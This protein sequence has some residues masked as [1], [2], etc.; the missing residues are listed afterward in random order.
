METN[1]VAAS[2]SVPVPHRLDAIERVLEGITGTLDKIGPILSAF[3]PAAAPFVA[4]VDAVGHVAE[5]VIT[6]LEGGNSVDA[7]AL[8]ASQLTKSTGNASLDA[9][10]VAIEEII[11]AAIP[12]LKYVAG[13]F[14][15]EFAPATPAPM[16]AS[17]NAV[18]LSSEQA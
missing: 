1:T 15:M 10:L 2:S 13:E 9:R 16:A 11:N 5:G 6:T 8:A 7:A 3:I 17:V 14:G 4:G 18:E 12:L